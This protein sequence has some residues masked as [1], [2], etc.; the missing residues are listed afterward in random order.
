MAGAVAY[1]ENVYASAVRERVCAMA[2]N[3]RQRTPCDRIA[4][5]QFSR[6]Q[7]KVH[8]QRQQ[9]EM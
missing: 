1:D 5:I 6:I 2:I 3:M 8:K 4:V 7:R 9:S